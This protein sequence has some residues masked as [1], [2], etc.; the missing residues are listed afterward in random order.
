MTP[1][2]TR[3]Q[4]PK[5]RNLCNHVLYPTNRSSKICVRG[6]Y[7][8]ALVPCPPI[9]SRIGERAL[10]E[11]QSALP[12]LRLVSVFRNAHPLRSPT[13]TRINLG[14][15]R[16]LL[17]SSSDKDTCNSPLSQSN[18]PSNTVSSPSRPDFQSASTPRKE[19]PPSCISLRSCTYRSFKTSNHSP[20][21]CSLDSQTGTSITSSAPSATKR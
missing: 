13:L 7:S 5:R 12:A 14:C 4:E 2:A 18:R 15:F 8:R 21:P 20:K 1:G 6:S 11:P 16:D 9:L 3:R 17:N 10:P 19:C